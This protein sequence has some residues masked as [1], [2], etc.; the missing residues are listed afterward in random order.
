MNNEDRAFKILEAC[1]ERREA[2]RAFLLKAMPLA[3]A[4]AMFDAL[5]IGRMP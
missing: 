5:P 1:D 3:S 2:R 4:G